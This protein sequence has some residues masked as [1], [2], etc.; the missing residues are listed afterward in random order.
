MVKRDTTPP[1][2]R[3]TPSRGPDGNGWYNREVAVAFDGGDALSGIASCT[4]ATYSGP[5]SGAARVSGSCRD[6]AGNTGSASYDLKYDATAPT[7]EA[8]PDRK[9]NAGGWYNRAIKVAFVGTDALSGVDSCAAPVEYK[10]PDTEKTAL[11]GT[12]RDKAGNTS[13]PVGFEV[14]YDTKPPSL[15]RVKTEI[16]QTGV[17]L[18]WTASADSLTFAIV[19]RP[20][21][22]GRKPSTIYT[23]KAKTFTDR[24]LQNGVKYRYTVTAYDQAGNG[25]AKALL[26]LPKSVKAT[27][28]APAQQKPATSAKPALRTPRVDARVTAPPLLS[29]TGLPNASYFNVQL[30]RDGQKILTVWPKAHSFRLQ[31]SWTYQG[32]R[33]TLTPGRYRWYVWPGFGSLSANRYGKLIGSRSFVVLRP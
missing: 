3:G 5:D 8:R 29:W 25:A 14:R 32:R 13:Q 28:A 12:C 7:V 18:R 11:S 10:G 17:V 31:A 20:G 21:L 24:R 15:G 9:P 1:S 26:A 2:A 22:N 30:Y 6:I 33:Y 27:R 4:T 19:R 23:G 16:S